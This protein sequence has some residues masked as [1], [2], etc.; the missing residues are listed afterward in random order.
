MKGEKSQISYLMNTNLL[1]ILLMLLNQ[2]THSLLTCHW[3]TSVATLS[4]S[5]IFWIMTRPITPSSVLVGLMSRNEGQLRKSSLWSF[6]VRNVSFSQRVRIL[7]PIQILLEISLAS[8][9]MQL[10]YELRALF[11]RTWWLHFQASFYIYQG[12]LNIY[13]WSYLPLLILS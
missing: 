3:L 9:L 13:F 4:E 5:Q 11:Y 6:T 2:V 7:S 12:S 8:L 1:C 10:T